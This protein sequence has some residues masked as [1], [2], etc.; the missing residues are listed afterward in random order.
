M[1]IRD[2]FSGDLEFDNELINLTTAAT[3]DTIPDTDP[4]KICV[5]ASRPQNGIGNP[6]QTHA[7]E[8]SGVSTPTSGISSRPIVRRQNARQDDVGVQFM[9][10]LKLEMM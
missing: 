9:H 4:D 7:H 5:D 10:M 1:N 8:K 3:S 6:E 2:D